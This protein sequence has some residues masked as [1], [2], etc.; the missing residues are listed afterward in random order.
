MFFSPY[1][2]YFDKNLNNPVFAAKND[3]EKDRLEDLVG[4]FPFIY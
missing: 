1:T 3:K 4:Q 2:T